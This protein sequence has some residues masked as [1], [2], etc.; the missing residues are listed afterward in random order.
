MV[1]TG[2]STRP[3]SGFSSPLTDCLLSGNPLSTRTRYSLLSSDNF[4]LVTYSVTSVTHILRSG[5]FKVLLFLYLLYRPLDLHQICFIL[6]FYVYTNFRFLFGRLF[7]FEYGYFPFLTTPSSLDTST[8]FPFLI[9]KDTLNTYST[10]LPTIKLLSNHLKTYEGRRK[11]VLY[12]G[13]VGY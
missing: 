11:G 10:S 3:L 4:L 8:R 6:P 1:P 5:L 7:L 13:K 12:V 2:V 9:K